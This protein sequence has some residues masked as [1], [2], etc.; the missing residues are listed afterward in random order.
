MPESIGLASGNG[1]RALWRPLPT[2]GLARQ[3]TVLSC[4]QLT[5]T[6]GGITALERLSF[7][8][9]RGQICAL[10][11]PNGAGKT[12]FFNC[13]SGL[14]AVDSGDIRFKGRSIVGM[15]PHALAALGIARTFQNL[16]LFESQSVLFNVLCG[17]HARQR[18]N[19]LTQCLGLG[20]VRR[21]EARA[22]EK[23]FT[24]LAR[25]NLAD[26][27]HR[28]A[29]ELSLA[30]RKRVELA[31]ALI[32]EPA[33][34]MLDEPAA[35]LSQDELETLASLL[36]ELRIQNGLTILLVEHRMRWLQTLCDRVIALDFGRKIAEG[37]PEVVREH[38]AVIAAWLGQST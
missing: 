29:G 12:T 28:R 2:A 18:G 24:W 19:A 25:L 14:Y 20:S 1:P 10:V 17:D 35:G 4:D 23:A 34:L 21:D 36:T 31:R 6:F 33:L 27:A 11:G 5:V 37:R 3:D 22:H 26:L 30:T 13:A 38:P 16:A 9:P 7:E 32:A 8:V 15:A